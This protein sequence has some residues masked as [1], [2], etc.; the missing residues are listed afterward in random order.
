MGVKY[1]EGNQFAPIL[2]FGSD[3]ENEG[4]SLI[5]RLAGTLDSVPT[6]TVQDVQATTTTEPESTNPPETA[7]G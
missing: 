4:N 1:Y 3:P 5:F 7:G 2:D 6:E